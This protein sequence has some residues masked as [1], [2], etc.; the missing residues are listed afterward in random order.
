MCVLTCSSDSRLS[1]LTAHSLNPCSPLSSST[2]EAEIFSVDQNPWNW[3]KS[4]TCFK[5]KT[6][7]KKKR[8]IIVLLLLP[9][10]LFCSLGGGGGATK[11]RILHRRGE[12]TI[13]KSWRWQRQKAQTSNYTDNCPLGIIHHTLSHLR[14]TCTRALWTLWTAPCSKPSPVLYTSS[15][16]TTTHWQNSTCTIFVNR[17]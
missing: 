4:R 11:A 3:E 1:Q 16:P 9:L 2:M 17:V 5:K 13:S 15:R 7:L 6:I 14:D 10:P 8:Q 12:Q